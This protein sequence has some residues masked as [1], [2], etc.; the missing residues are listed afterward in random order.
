MN[1][2]RK[3]MVLVLSL[4]LFIITGCGQSKHIETVA[5]P[6]LIPSN[7]QYPVKI[8]NYDSREKPAVYTYYKA[9][10]KVV[11]THPGATELMLDLGLENHILST[12][13]L[14]GAPLPKHT[15]K[16][17]KLNIMKAVYTPSV[18]EL[19]I[20]QPDMIIGWSHHFHD[21]ALGDVNTWHDRGIAT[22]IMPVSLSKHKPTIDSAVYSLINDIGKIFDIQSKTNLYIQEYQRRISY[23]EQS[24]ADIQ[25][26]KTVMVL[27]DHGNGNY[28][29]YDGNY[30]ISDMISVAG[31][32]HIAD[33]MKSIVGAERVLSYDPDFIIYVSTN[34]N[35]S[36]KDLTDQEAITH[37]NQI[38]E[39]KNIR[40]IQEGKII[41]LPFFTVNNGG[42]RTVDSIEKIA[43]ALYPEKF[44]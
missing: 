22:Y 42:I 29:L 24:I 44:R 4:I 13:A 30:L 27:Q 39:L 5:R 2:F 41:N 14:Y 15:E 8:I 25:T 12:I 16:Y 9:P 17:A 36:N 38:E 37:L 21:S 20:M 28:S 6:P 10:R 35:G 43:H 34:R 40:A 7:T 32:I 31:G 3:T 1:K 18:E 23:I 33:N 11:I 19:I 26:K